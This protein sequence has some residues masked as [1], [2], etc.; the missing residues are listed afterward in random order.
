MLG[1]GALEPGRE[2]APALSGLSPNRGDPSSAAA[3]PML[4]ESVCLGGRR[5]GGSLNEHSSLAT[6]WKGDLQAFKPSLLLL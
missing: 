5:G 6:T 3:R 4:Q 2:A 1:D